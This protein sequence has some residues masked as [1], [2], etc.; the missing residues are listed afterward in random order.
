MSEADILTRLGHKRLV[1]L[2]LLWLI[3]SPEGLVDLKSIYLEPK[4][5]CMEKP[6][7]NS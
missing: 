3:S 1:V 6:D 7:E 4:K 5:P 2:R